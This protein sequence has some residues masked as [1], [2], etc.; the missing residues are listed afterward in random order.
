[1]A[2]RARV[3]VTQERR[4]L[5]LVPAMEFGDMVV[6]LE[7][8]DQVFFNAKPTVSEVERKLADFS[9][10]DF[11][12]PL[13]D[14]VSIGIACAAAARA[15]NG[16]FKLLKFDRIMTRDKGRPVYYPVEVNMSNGVGG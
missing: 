7:E 6:L 3:F 4:G 9:D 15:N 13:G 5:N 1:M 16:R 12:L 8:G 14:P 10:Q 2:K 11:I